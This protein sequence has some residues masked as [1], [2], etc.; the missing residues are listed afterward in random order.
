MNGNGVDHLTRELLKSGIQKPTAGFNSRI[1]ERITQQVLV[2]KKE[3]SK[4]YM[5]S[6]KTTPLVI[7]GIIVYML[8][9]TLVF[10]FLQIPPE[11]NGL[12]NILHDIKEKLP[13]ILTVIAIIGAFPFFS[14]LDKT[15]S[16]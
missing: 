11:E 10:Y 16:F 6:V 13:Y 4:V 12:I 15:L 5:K 7:I 8:A 1:M 3:P 2:Q 14:A 9:V